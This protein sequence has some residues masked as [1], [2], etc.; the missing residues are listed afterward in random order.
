MHEVTV[1]LLQRLELIKKNIE[2]EQEEALAR[3][4]ASR[5]DSSSAPRGAAGGHK[6]NQSGAQPKGVQF[7][8][9]RQAPTLN[10]ELDSRTFD[11]A[12]ISSFEQS[13]KR[14]AME[15]HAVSRSLHALS[16]DQEHEKMHDFIHRQRQQE[17]QDRIQHKLWQN[18]S[19]AQRVEEQARS[20]DS[21]RVAAA[22]AKDSQYQQ[23]QHEDASPLTLS[24]APRPSVLHDNN[25]HSR[26]TSMVPKFRP[27]TDIAPIISFIRKKAKKELSYKGKNTVLYNLLQ[28]SQD[29]DQAKQE[30][31]GPAAGGLLTSFGH[32]SAL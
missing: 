25:R 7:D 11:F 20:S 5:L 8:D 31:G 24:R 19:E 23:S 14:R 16:R 6:R 10:A 2:Q 9:P 1:D 30:N 17:F 18:R 3:S 28:N 26:S 21:D 29:A 22:S 27:G 12:L 4:R 15:K 13:N 32:P